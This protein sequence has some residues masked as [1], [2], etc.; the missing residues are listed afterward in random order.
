MT[1][2]GESTRA[3]DFW[4]GFY[5]P[6]VL[7][8]FDLSQ[9]WRWV[10][11]ADVSD[12]ASAIRALYPHISEEGV[13]KLSGVLESILEGHPRTT[14]WE[15]S[16]LV[17]NILSMLACTSARAATRIVDALGGFVAQ[18]RRVTKPVPQSPGKVIVEIANTCN[19]DCVM[20][21]VGARG[22]DPSRVMSLRFFRELA[23]SVLRQAK[24]V[25][26]NGLGES[27]VVPRFL[28]YL[29]AV[30]DHDVELELVTNLSVSDT[31]V[32][33]RLAD[34]DMTVFV[35]CDAVD[36]QT[37]TRIR[38]NLNFDQFLAN[39]AFLSEQMRENRRDPL[40][41]QVIMTLLESNFRQLPAMVE[42]AAR[43]RMGGVIANMVKGGNGTWKTRHHAEIVEVFR[44]A[45]RVA[46]R[47][48]VQLMV[49]NHIEGRPIRDDFVAE[50]NYRGC[51]TF[52]EEVF[53]RFNGDICPCNMM[54]PYVYGN[55][56]RHSLE[57]VMWSVP[58]RL[59]DYLMFTQAK[60]PYCVNCYYLRPGGRA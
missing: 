59:F 34:L 48:G 32:L 3:R 54:N 60:H 23:R 37:L 45:H 14:S 49:P 16:L 43:Y 38:R 53:I 50:S 36:E 18:G 7:E 56:R 47:L 10:E 15:R 24:V 17:A 35:S 6:V 11:A 40:K 44:H 27:T 1:R 39:L 26:L 30:A 21:G 13:D 28:D 57:E 25:R 51:P 29:D 9:E 41:T 52:L 31:A 4:K 12:I 19:L 8:R 5:D 33:E 2:L 22:F 46:E 58:K 42:F 20:C 55:L